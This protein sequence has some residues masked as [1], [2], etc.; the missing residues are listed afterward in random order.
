MVDLVPIVSQMKRFLY[1]KEAAIF[2]FA[3]LVRLTLFIILYYWFEVTGHMSDPM[4]DFPVLG[5]DSSDYFVLTENLR[6]N[7]IFSSSYEAPYIPESFR[8]PGY[9]FF[10]YLFTFVP[11]SYVSAMIAQILLAAGSCVLLYR[12]GKRFLSEKVALIAALLFCVEPTSVL[13]STIIM[14][15]TVFVFALLLG[16][17][18][19]FNPIKNIRLGILAAFAAGLLF[20]YA[21]LVRT[22]AQYLA[23]FVVIAYLFIF[24]KDLRPFTHT[25]IKI[26][27]FALGML[28]VLAPWALRQHHWFNTYTLSSTP[29]INFTQYN[30]VYFY[31]H[32][33]GI[34]KAEAQKIHS[35][36]IPYPQDSFWFRSL[37]NEPIFKQLMKD[38][39][40]GNIIPYASFHLAKTL[41]FFIN[42]SFRDINR[43]V[44]VFPPPKEVTNFTDLLLKKDFGGIMKF[45]T[46]PQPDLWMLLIGSSVWIV[47]SLLS[48]AAGLIAV[49]LRRKNVWFI[50]FALGIVFYFGILSSP[51][52][53]PRYRM[54]A[55]PFMLL[56]AVDSAFLLW[57]ARKG[58][59][60]VKFE[61]N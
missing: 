49:I 25:A 28:L 20:G 42:D 50:L 22:I 37:V 60:N 43:M 56:L 24:R 55:A 4:F 35:D 11:F 51:V 59:K 17:Y 46:T 7:G 13:Y 39:L 47:I 15:D 21:V 32:Q 23:V 3:F 16:I 34:S 26:A 53:Q 44:G 30:L 29:Y 10:L 45:F 36:P 14:S 6:H 5:G 27:V 52:I 61:A 19:F 2:L 8:L 38:G 57:A 40:H 1:T 31:A 58:W 41:P 18:L 48:I 9:P 33:H 12:L 54:P